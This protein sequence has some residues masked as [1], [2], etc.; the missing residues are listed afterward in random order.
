GNRPGSFAAVSDHCAKAALTLAASNGSSPRTILPSAPAC[1][2]LLFIRAL[3]WE[4]GSDWAMATVS[5]TATAA[6]TRMVRFIRV[7]PS[8][9]WK[10]VAGRHGWSASHKHRETFFIPGAEER[11]KTAA[12]H[13]DSVRA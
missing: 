7:A 9:D 13:H 4:I 2:P 8:L 10:S 3:R 11:R 5:P 6:M 12:G 1:W